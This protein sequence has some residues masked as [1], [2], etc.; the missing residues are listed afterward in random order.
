MI[1]YDLSH[2]NSKLNNSREE[3][4]AIAKV[5]PQQFTETI[6]PSHRYSQKSQL[7]HLGL[8]SGGDGK[9]VGIKRGDESKTVYSC[10]A[11]AVLDVH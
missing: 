4:E 6:I 11:P 10:S 3:L 2:Q 5:I 8:L 9:G 7:E 1:Q